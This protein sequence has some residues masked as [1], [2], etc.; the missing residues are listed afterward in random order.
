MD[1]RIFLREVGRA[2][3]AFVALLGTALVVTI[4]APVG[5]G[6]LAQTRP[7]AIALPQAKVSGYAT[8][9]IVVTKGEEITF[10]N[11]D[12]DLHDVVQDTEKDGFGAKKMMR[13]C[14]PRGGHEHDHGEACPLF[15]TGLIGLG[16][17]TRIL[18][19]K[20]LEAGKTYSFFCT[21]HHGMKGSLVVQ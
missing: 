2:R 18:G 1:A 15:W 9:I 7:G 5:A 10:T 8:P 11:L 14:E 12:T 6:S 17:T 13:W 19:L 4:S 21:R 16:D 3:L 20:N